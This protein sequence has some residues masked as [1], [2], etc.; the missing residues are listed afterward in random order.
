MKENINNYQNRYFKRCKNT[1]S[2]FVTLLISMSCFA[3]Q[4]VS[5]KAFVKDSNGNVLVHHDIRVR[6][7]IE[8]PNGGSEYIEWHDTTTNENGL[9]ILNIGEGNPG[10][11]HDFTAIDWGAERYNL[12][13]AIRINTTGSY[14]VFDET[15]FKSVPYALIAEN[16]RNQTFKSE[17][18]L[19]FAENITDDFVFG[20]TQLDNDPS[21]EN[22][23]SRMFFDKS[24]GA[25]RAGVARDYAND[26][27]WDDEYVGSHSIGMGRKALASGNSSIALGWFTEA[28]NQSAVAIGIALKAIGKF[29]VALGS[30][31]IAQSQN[32]TAIGRYNIGGGNP[33]IWLDDDPLFEIGNGRPITSST[34]EA[35]NALTVYKN[36][37]AKFDAKI[38]T[39]KTGDANMLPIA[40]GTVESN[41][42]IL[43][44]TGNFTAS[45]NSNVFSITVTGENLTA[46]NS[47]CSI[48]P[49]STSP[50]TSS[51]I[52]SGGDL[53]VYIFNSSGTQ[54]ASTFQF[55]IYK[56]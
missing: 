1:I 3:Q 38:Q 13:V 21:T 44:G 48:V 53:R 45:V 37:N 4:G 20:S 7:I 17:D 11:F 30:H 33:E 12:E 36:G 35:N 32:S 46:S 8:K 23:D 22:D 47:S 15:P 39:T 18:G 52:H 24:K 41:G 50:R 10:Q 26:Y 42:N 49:Y 56:L 14:I 43:S 28:T 16:V 54:L 25:F 27:F 55:V 9:F 31:T 40:Y 5:Y 51:I 19:T 2:L 29:S 34:I 6:F